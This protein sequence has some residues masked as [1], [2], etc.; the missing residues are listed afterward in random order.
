M[1]CEVAKWGNDLAI[2]LPKELVDRLG[3]KENDEVR[4][5]PAGDGHTI[6]IEREAMTSADCYSVQTLPT[7]YPFTP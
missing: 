6:S 1:R 5:V 7:N 2:R 3:L 4:L